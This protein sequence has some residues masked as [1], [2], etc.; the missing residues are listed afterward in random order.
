V[1]DG[2]LIV[3]LEHA[4]IERR[5]R[6]AQRFEQRLLRV[7]PE[8]SA[9]EP[10]QDVAGEIYAQ[11]RVLVMMADREAEPGIGD[12]SRL[13]L[14]IVGVGIEVRADRRLVGEAC[15]CDLGDVVG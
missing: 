7:P 6:Q 13:P 9:G 2:A 12:A 8:V 3:A 10:L 15:P 11:V 1:A 4:R 5:S 14:E